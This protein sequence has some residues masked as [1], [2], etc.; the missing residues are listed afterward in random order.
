MTGKSLEIAVL[1]A[2]A[3]GSLFG[4]RLALAGHAVTLLDVNAAHLAAINEHGLKLVTDEGECRV[5]LPALRPEE[6]DG[7]PEL[8][9]L[10][11]KTL[12]TRAA[13]ESVRSRLGADT[14]VL[15]LQN[16][17]GNAEAIGEFVAPQ[18]IIVGMTTYPGD[19]AGPGHV[20][21]HGPGVIH[22]MSADGAASP[23]LNA[24]A[25]A[26]NGAG[27]VCDV[28]PGVHVSIWEKVAFNG[29]LNSI[30]SATRSVVGGVAAVPV[31]RA[32]ALAVVDEVVA[33]A[34][35][36]GIAADGPK[37]RALV[38]HALEAHGGHKP[39]MLQDV[40]AGRQTEIE[41]ING[42]VVAAADRLGVAVPNTRALLALLRV[43]DGNLKAGRGLD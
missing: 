20:E 3:M 13:L 25:A 1:G 23:E 7:R 41:S 18:R 40:L 2:G 16:G 6:Y 22:M 24:I 19:L 9:I 42:A 38:E 29:A 32:L 27:L 17:L 5:T 28:D 37:V 31:A 10:F 15:S 33:V 11:T 21:S 35:A 8:L 39:S 34:R 36:A 14:W 4:A 30:C 43:V 26:L 12:H